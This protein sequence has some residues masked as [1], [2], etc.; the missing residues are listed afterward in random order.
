M[1]AF[2]APDGVHWGVEAKAPGASNI[3]ILFHY[4][5]RKSARRSRYAWLNW[6]GPE[7]RNV[8]ARLDPRTVVEQLDDREIAHLFRR[9]MPI[10][11]PAYGPSNPAAR[12]R[13][14]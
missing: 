9:S 1:R 7:A 11:A 14:G 10:T 8:T 5:D 3:M 12:S 2:T 4:P 13:S 6:Q